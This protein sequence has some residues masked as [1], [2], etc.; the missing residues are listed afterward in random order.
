MKVYHRTS[1]DA[2]REILRT[3]TLVSLENTGE[4]FVSNRR[5]GHATGHGA[6]VVVL[7]IPRDVL[8]VDDWFPDGEAHY[9]VHRTKAEK[10]LVR[11]EFEAADNPGAV[12][13]LEAAELLLTTLRALNMM[14]PDNKAGR[15]VTY[16]SSSPGCPYW[17]V[18]AALMQALTLLV[19]GDGDRAEQLMNA[20]TDNGESVAYSLAWLTAEWATDN[21][22]DDVED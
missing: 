1:P 3:R 2:A 8:R 14:D 10:W 19:G 7:D 18:R 6:A 4:V 9:A 21:D 12:V 5:D 16:A 15:D 22:D 20:T 17:L 13:D 11:V